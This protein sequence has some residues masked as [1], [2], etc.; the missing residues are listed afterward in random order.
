M[1][2]DLVSLSQMVQGALIKT[3]RSRLSRLAQ[4]LNVDRHTIERA[5]RTTTGKSFRQLQK[6]AVLAKSLEL[7]KGEPTLSIKEIAFRVGFES[8]QGFHRFV[9]R[10]CG[11]TPV[12]IRRTAFGVASPIQKTPPLLKNAPLD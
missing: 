5:V 2:Y 9:K 7:L 4:S 3:P 12:A 10:A 8:P 11:R 1:S 6:E